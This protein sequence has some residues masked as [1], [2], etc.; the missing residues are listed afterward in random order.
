MVTTTGKQGETVGAVEPEFVEELLALAVAMAP[1]FAT[2]AAKYGEE[3]RRRWGG[4]RPYI[5]HR[6]NVSE[7]DAAIRRD[8]LGGMRFKEMER[9]HGLSFR[10]IIR[11]VKA[12]G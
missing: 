6:R 3:V 12:G 7:R 5:A 10:Q 8:Y 11:I 4:N 9:R 1:E 2:H